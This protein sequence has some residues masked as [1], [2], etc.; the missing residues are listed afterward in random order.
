MST[1]TALRH[2][3]AHKN[4]VC[5]LYKRSLKLS[6]DWLIIRDWWHEE[7]VSIRAQIEE[8]RDETNDVRINRLVAD[9]ENTLDEWKHPSPY[10]IP[11]DPG[12][13][14]WQRNLPLPNWACEME[15]YGGFD[16]K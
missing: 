14:K 15:S 16:F 5:R 4:H 9:F 8:H 1:G 6:R 2:S 10:I 11:T 13:T 7:V 12:G 3:L